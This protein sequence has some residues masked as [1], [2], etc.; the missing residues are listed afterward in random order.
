VELLWRLLLWCIVLPLLIIVAAP[1][2][3]LVAA[4]GSPTGYW[5]RVKRYTGELTE[6][7]W[8]SAGL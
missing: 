5:R 3:L 1:L 6:L 8:F 2:I 4:F 7:W